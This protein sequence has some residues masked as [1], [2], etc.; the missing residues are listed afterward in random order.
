MLPYNTDMEPVILPEFGRNLQ[1]LID[2]CIAIPDRDERTACAFAIAE[3][4]AGQFPHLVGEGGD[5]S[6]IWNNLNVMSKFKLDVDFPCEVLSEEKLHPVPAKLPYTSSRIRFR[7]YGKNIE[8]M[9]DKVCEMED[10]PEKVI[11]ISLIANQMKKLMLQHNP[12]GVDDAKIIR[13]LNFYSQGRLNLDPET[14]ILHEFKEVPVVQMNNN[15]KRKK[16]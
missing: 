14:Y 5:M 3:T 9:I 1:G 2:Y 15:K 7:H 8:G 4:M 12:E 13:D 11:A 10:S 16:K 6:V